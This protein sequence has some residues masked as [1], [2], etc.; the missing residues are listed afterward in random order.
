MFNPDKLERRYIMTNSDITNNNAVLAVAAHPDDIE[1]MMAGTLLQLANSGFDIHMWNLSSGQCGSDVMSSG[2]IAS[3]RWLEASKSAALADAWLHPPITED[4]HILY[5]QHLIRKAATVIRSIKPTIILLPSP[6]DYMEDHQNTSR[7]IVTA[8]FVRG[9]K[10]YETSPPS[11]P[12][13]EATVL[14]HALPHGLTDQLRNRVIPG[15]YVN[16]TSVMERKQSMLACHKSQKE[17][18]D[19]TQGIGAY[20]TLMEEMASEVG[21]MSGS[22]SFAEGWRRH[23]HWGFAEKHAD[24]LS[25]ALGDR[26][27]INIDYEKNL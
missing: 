11:D 23:S 10:N 14:Y 2:S 15:Q 18:L 4:I 20:L 16:I 7:I 25:E 12:W 19:K 17:W 1:F 5:S 9:M 26:C 27:I 3:T 13:Y 6:Q 24:P 21:T 22:F 8:A